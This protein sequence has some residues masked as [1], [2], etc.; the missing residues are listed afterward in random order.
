MV[1]TGYT[2]RRQTA[3]GA[4]VPVG[5]QRKAVGQ[6]AFGLQG[7]QACI[8]PARTSGVAH[9]SKDPGIAAESTKI[10]VT[11]RTNHLSNVQAAT[12]GLYPNGPTRSVDK[13]VGRVF[14]ALVR[15]V[16]EQ[17]VAIFVLLFIATESWIGNN[18]GV[19]AID[20]GAFEHNEVVVFLAHVGQTTLETPSQIDL[21]VAALSGGE[22]HVPPRKIGADRTAQ[23]VTK[24]PNGGHETEL[25][26]MRKGL[27]NFVIRQLYAA[28]KGA[29]QFA[30]T[31]H[32]VIENR[33]DVTIH[34]GLAEN[35]AAAGTVDARR[36][37][38]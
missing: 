3:T 18:P 23:G 36:T 37:T 12:L 21:H 20:T 8:S 1:A 34:A 17:V 19:V 9:A 4:V 7:G 27:A 29:R 15:F 31:A 38:I 10:G 33:H 30:K 35:I 32:V 2:F 11:R 16:P 13:V 25:M 26:R 5:R 28:A 22:T 14:C 24:V 6:A